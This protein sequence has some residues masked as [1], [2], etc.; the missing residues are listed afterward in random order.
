MDSGQKIIKNTDKSNAESDFSRQHSLKITISFL[1][2]F[3]FRLVLQMISTIVQLQVQ[4][5]SKYSFLH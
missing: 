2:F 3:Y 1:S 5:Y 4:L